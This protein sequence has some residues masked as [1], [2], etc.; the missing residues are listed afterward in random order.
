MAALAGSL[1]LLS[2]AAFSLLAIVVGRRLVRLSQQTGRAPERSLGLGIALTAGFGYG[3]LMFALVVR[4]TMGAET[5][6]VFAWV[7]AAG[8][9]FHNTGV[10]FVLD[11]VRRVFRPEE[12]WARTLWYTMGFVLWAGWFADALS[13][14]LTAPQPGGFYWVAF[15]VIGTYPIWTGMESLRYW[16]LMRKR[17]ALGLAEPLVANRFL[18]WA[19]ASICTV[20]SIWVV[21]APVFLGYEPGSTGEILARSISMLVTSAFGIATICAYWLTFFPPGWYRARFPSN[22]PHPEGG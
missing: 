4:Q 6:S 13:G 7:T 22:V 15:S 3:L 16:Q 9:I 20:A 21:N 11:F 2:T 14:G 17:V 5:P 8:W 19:I 12:S 18:L 1:Y 10:M